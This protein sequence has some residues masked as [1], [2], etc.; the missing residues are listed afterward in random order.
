[1]TIKEN[2][3]ITLKVTTSKENLLSVLKQKGF[4]LGRTFSLDDYYFIPNEINVENLTTREILS[5][6]VLIRN[7]FENNVYSKKITYKVKDIDNNGN[8]LSQ[9]VVRSNWISPNYEH[10]RR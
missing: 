8:I 7:I 2:N 5:K 9:I 1:M 6:C 4:T 10:K 3:E